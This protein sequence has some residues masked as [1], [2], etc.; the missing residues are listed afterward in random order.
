[1]VHYSLDKTVAP[2]RRTPWPLIAA[3]VVAVG[4]CALVLWTHSRGDKAGKTEEAVEPV[5]VADAPART[6]TEPPPA[7]NDRPSSPALPAVTASTPA[8]TMEGM[9]KAQSLRADGDL[10]AAREEALALLEANP[11]PALRAQVEAFL[12][13]VNIELVLTPR[14]MPEKDVYVV[15]SGDSLDKIAR[16]F[17][18]TIDLV[19]KSNNI[20][21]SLIRVGDRLRIFTGDFSITVDK[22]D[23]DLL[24]N[25]NGRFFKRYR[26]GTGQYNKTPVGDFK[27]TDRIAQPTW[28]RPDGKEIPYGDPANLLGTHWLALNVRGYGIHGTWE[29]DTIGKQL[30]A[31][32]VRMLNDEVEELFTLVTIGTPVAI[33][34]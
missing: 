14:D 19:R 29:P 5:A 2:P 33:T 12:G 8:E 22:S 34:D 6:E 11:A 21:G 20:S 18:T 30:S 15:Q 32:C 31:G 26:V 28:W 25:M 23:N 10:L 9:R 27:I 16:K 1:M 24:V 3:L 17:D 7:G 4:I 13:E